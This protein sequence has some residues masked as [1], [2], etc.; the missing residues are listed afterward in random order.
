MRQYKENL[1]LLNSRYTEVERQ[2]L[3][4]FAKE[5]QSLKLD[6]F[7]TE[8]LRDTSGAPVLGP[9]ILG[10][11]VIYPEMWWLVANLL[12]DDVIRFKRD[13]YF[14]PRT[15]GGELEYIEL[16]EKGCT[17]MQRWVSGEAI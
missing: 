6:F 1:D 15:P 12:D 17:L 14:N 7:K 13:K 3:K 16:T 4:I 9:A 2:L 10:S 11:L 8:D 5:W